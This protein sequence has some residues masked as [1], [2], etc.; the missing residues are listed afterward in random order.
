[1]AGNPPLPWRE[2]RRKTIKRSY[3]SAGLVDV[4]ARSKTERDPRRISDDERPKIN[5]R[6]KIAMDSFVATW[7]SSNFERAC[8]RAAERKRMTD[9]G[10]SHID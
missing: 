9:H 3:R 8:G 4:A 7:S 6:N 5:K 2:H 10:S 1:M